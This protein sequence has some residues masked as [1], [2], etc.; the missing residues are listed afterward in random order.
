MCSKWL[1]WALQVEKKEAEEE[2]CGKEQKNNDEEV[3]RGE[4]EEKEK[5]SGPAGG[6]GGEKNEMTTEK[7]TKPSR[8]PRRPK[9]IQI[10]VTLLD[11]ILYECELDVRTFFITILHLTDQE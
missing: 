11:G 9:T 6:G 7:E 8:T 2:K 10:K 5:E 1:C 3:V 4:E